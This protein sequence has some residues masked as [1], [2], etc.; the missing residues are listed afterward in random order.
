[1]YSFLDYNNIP[2]CLQNDWVV[3]NHKA[4]KET[5]EAFLS[6]P[7]DMIQLHELKNSIFVAKGS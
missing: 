1:M 5:T 7:T 3:Q 2:E 6:T 4:D